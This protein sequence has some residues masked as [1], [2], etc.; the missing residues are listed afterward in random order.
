MLTSQ[1][2]VPS[3][4]CG[5]RRPRGV[6]GVLVLCTWGPASRSARVRARRGLRRGGSSVWLRGPWLEGCLAGAELLGGEPRAR[7][8]D[9]L[10]RRRCEL[11]EGS[12]LELHSADP[13]VRPSLRA[14]CRLTATVLIEEDGTDDRSAYRI[15]LP[16]SS[17]PGTPTSSPPDPGDLRRTAAATGREGSSWFALPYMERRIR[18]RRH[19]PWSFRPPPA[20]GPGGGVPPGRTDPRHVPSG[21]RTSPAIA[22]HL[23]CDLRPLLDPSLSSQTTMIS[24]GRT[25]AQTGR[26]RLPSP[27]RQAPQPRM[28]S[29]ELWL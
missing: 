5:T 21:P 11:P 22:Q 20:S 7:V 13:Q 10:E 14:W 25:F 16:S 24:G 4:T 28:E 27:G 3:V 17:A 8:L 2:N 6:G 15:K 12:V 23:R 9:L 26:S 19:K 1:S 29:P 18:P